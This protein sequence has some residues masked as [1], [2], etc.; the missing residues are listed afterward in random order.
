LTQSGH[1]TQRIVVAQNDGRNPFRRSQIPAVI[2]EGAQ[3]HAWGRPCADA[4]SSK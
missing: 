4:I 1:S 3:F 2:N